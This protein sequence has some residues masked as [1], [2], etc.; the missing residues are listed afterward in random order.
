MFEFPESFQNLTNET[1]SNPVIDALAR[2]ELENRYKKPDATIN[3]SP[4]PTTSSGQHFV[5]FNGF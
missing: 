5:Q 3:W 1:C 2:P 4:Q